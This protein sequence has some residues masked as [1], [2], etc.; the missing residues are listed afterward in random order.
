MRRVIRWLGAVGWGSMLRYAFE[1][2]TI[3]ISN[4]W[5]RWAAPPGLCIMLVVMAL[6]LVGFSVEAW[7]NPR[8]NGK[9]S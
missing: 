7:A 1:C 4:V 5:V 9:R 8:L 3:F 2:P 6:K